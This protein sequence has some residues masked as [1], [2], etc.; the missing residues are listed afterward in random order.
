[1]Y[2]TSAN[3]SICLTIILSDYGSANC[4]DSTLGYIKDHGIEFAPAGPANPK[5]NGT[6]EGAFSQ[7]KQ[8]LGPIR[9]AASSPKQLAESILKG[10]I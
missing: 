8:A 3:L 6:L 7:M 2:E 1:M 10:C 4:A 9:I 5:G